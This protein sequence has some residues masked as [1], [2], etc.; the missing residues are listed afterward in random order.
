MTTQA[1][2]QGLGQFARW[3]FTLEHPNDHVVELHHEGKFV[4]WFS[5]TGATE[6][7]LQA[8]C[9]RHLVNNHGWDGCLWSR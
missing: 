4:A 2:A 9:A 5:Q 8:E 1:Q 6:H 3:G 7:S